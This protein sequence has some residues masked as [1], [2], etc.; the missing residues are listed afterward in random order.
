MSEDCQESDEELIRQFSW[1]S[2]HDKIEEKEETVKSLKEVT[3]TLTESMKDMLNTTVKLG[4][5][6]KELAEKM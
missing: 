2:L 5:R 4:E 1:T 3:Q 6:I